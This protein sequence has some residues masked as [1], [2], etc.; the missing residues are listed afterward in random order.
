MFLFSQVGFT[1]YTWFNQPK[2]NIMSF[3]V[4]PMA[5]TPIKVK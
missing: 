1:N 2:H 4:H 5:K 3:M